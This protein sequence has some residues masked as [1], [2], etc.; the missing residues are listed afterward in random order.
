MH[1]SNLQTQKTTHFGE[2]MYM[3]KMDILNNPDRRTR[4]AKGAEVPRVTR[5]DRFDKNMML[6]WN[7]E[8]PL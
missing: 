2:E 1:A 3:T 5:Q 4:W 7:F 6:L 8:C